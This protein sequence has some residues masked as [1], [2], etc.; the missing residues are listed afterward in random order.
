VLSRLR[1]DP[2][3][4]ALAVLTMVA[5]AFLWARNGA[6]AT[7][8]LLCLSGVIAGR[9][10]GLPDR[11]LVPAAFGLALILW[12]VWVDPPSTA[13]KT[14]A[15]AHFGGGALI[16]WALAETLRPRLPFPVW[17]IAVLGGVGS[18]A[19][20]WELAEWSADRALD[21]GLIPSERD[22]AADIFFGLTG[23]ASAIGLSGLLAL[24]RSG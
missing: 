4:F 8:C 11:A 6:A 12:M 21:T 24:R 22:S 13:H 2:F 23:G 15:L 14:S 17:A 16:G 7:T 19:V 20:T 18:L 3:S 5:L 9:L 1:I 10:A